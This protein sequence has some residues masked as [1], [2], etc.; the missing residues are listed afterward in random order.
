VPQRIFVTSTTDYREALAAKR[1]P[2]GW[3]EL[4]AL[5]TTLASHAEEHMARLDRTERE[6]QELARLEARKSTQ[7]SNGAR[8]SF[9]GR[10]FGRS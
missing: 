3:N 2:A 8:A 4:G 5:A 7:T 6:A 9:L 10:L 1:A